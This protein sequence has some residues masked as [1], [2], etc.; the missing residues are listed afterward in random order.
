M[1]LAVMALETRCGAV[2][3]SVVVCVVESVWMDSGVETRGCENDWHS[4][5]VV[6]G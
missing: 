2:P 1:V 3:V 5:S 4:A 6:R